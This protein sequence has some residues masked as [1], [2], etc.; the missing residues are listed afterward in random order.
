MI[1]NVRTYARYRD[2]EGVT[3]EC[4]RAD[5]ETTWEPG[6][7][8]THMRCATVLLLFVIYMQCVCGCRLI[9]AFSTLPQVYAL[10]ALGNEEEGG[11]CTNL[12]GI[13]QPGVVRTKEG[14]RKRNIY[15]DY[16]VGFGRTPERLGGTDH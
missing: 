16:A 8:R 5:G 9:C 4:R 15:K 1:I 2:L 3:L 7:V 14:T 10:E 12:R 6:M 11:G 13:G